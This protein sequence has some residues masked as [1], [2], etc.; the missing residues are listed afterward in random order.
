M[1]NKISGISIG[2]SELNRHRDEKGRDFSRPG[3][4]MPS[5]RDSCTARSLPL[6]SYRRAGAMRAG[7]ATMDLTEKLS[8]WGATHAAA[9][10]AARAAQSEDGCAAQARQ[11]EAQALRER[12][13]RL[14][15]EIYG[16][17]GSRR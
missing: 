5:L 17:L 10:E 7:Y 12:A 8:L 11:R 3:D 4:I 13:D 2:K 1:T 14:H 16:E 6:L 15:R 9:Q